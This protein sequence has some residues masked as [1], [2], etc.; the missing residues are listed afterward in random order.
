[1]SY[2]LF[3]ICIC[4]PLVALFVWPIHWI[5]FSYTQDAPYDPRF[6]R[7]GSYWR[8]FAWAMGV[9]LICNLLYQVVN[10]S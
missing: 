1:M 9:L 10:I 4:A 3:F 7:Q 6:Y 8:L 5:W 2:P